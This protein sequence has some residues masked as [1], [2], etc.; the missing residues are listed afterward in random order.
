LSWLVFYCC[1]RDRVHNGGV[2]KQL[3]AHTFL[4]N[5]EREKK[6][7]REG[8]REGGG[9]EGG[10]RERERRELGISG[11]FCKLRFQCPTPVTRLLQ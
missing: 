3:R 9:R 4:H 5:W 1:L 8:G 10:G 2:K 11:V 6:G 7:G